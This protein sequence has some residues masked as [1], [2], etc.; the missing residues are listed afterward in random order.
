ML[1]DSTINLRLPKKEKERLE[2]LAWRQRTSI[3]ELIRKQIKGVLE[4]V[5]NK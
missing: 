4:D 3:S 2:E 5:K 1:K